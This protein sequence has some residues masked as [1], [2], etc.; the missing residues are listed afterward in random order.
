LP[1]EP[2]T[3]QQWISDPQALK[4]GTTMPPTQADSETL[5]AVATYLS[6]LR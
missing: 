2:R 4:K 1:N 6:S 3:L 5:Q